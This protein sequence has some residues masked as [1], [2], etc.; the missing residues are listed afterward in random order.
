MTQQAPSHPLPAVLLCARDGLILHQTLYVAAKLGVADHLEDG[1]RSAAELARELN[2]NEGALYRVL[3]LL[4]SQGIFEED[5]ARCFRNN[6][7]SGFLRTGVPGSV[8]SL[9]IFWGSDS[10]IRVLDRS[11]TAFRLESRRELSFRARTG[12][13]T[14]VGIRNRRASSTTR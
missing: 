9:F 12:L 3:C 2:V 11:C 7:V 1:S 5:D 4:A 6:Q 14:F 8:R 13:N 10:T